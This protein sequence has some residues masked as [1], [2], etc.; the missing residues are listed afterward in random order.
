MYSQ[1]MNQPPDAVPAV[2]DRSPRAGRYPTSKRLLDLG[3]GSL[4]FVAALPVLAVIRVAMVASGDRGPFLFRATRIGEDAREIT[5]LKIRTM[6]ADAGGSPLT[7]RDDDR[8]TRVG[9]L[10]RRTKLDEL[11]QLW[12]V[13]AGQMALVGPRPEDP[14][15]VDLSKPDHLAVFTQRPGITGLAQLAF[16]NEAELLDGD[17]VDQTYRE[18]VL[19]AKLQLDLE[20]LAHRSLALDLKLIAR[21]A[22]AIVGRDGANEKGLPRW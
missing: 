3:L 22:A 12:N 4:A 14:S 10:L 6:R 2:A 16:R 9:R 21:T 1:V 18:V 8:V 15:Y 11:P 5:V 7:T 20:Y 13:L 19:P 17:D